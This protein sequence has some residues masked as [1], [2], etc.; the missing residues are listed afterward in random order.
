MAVILASTSAIRLQLLAAAGVSVTVCPARVDESAIR[1]ALLADRASPRD[2]VDYLAEV[3]ARKISE[4]QPEALVLGC[5]QVL[6]L[7]GQIL[8]KPTSPADARAQL[9]RLRG[10]SHRLLSAVVAYESAKPVWRYIGE[11]QLTMRDISDGF[12]DDYLARNWES[13]RNSVGGYKIE[14]EGVRLFSA[15]DGDHFT[16]LGLPLLP[17]LAWLGSRGIIAT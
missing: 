16:I 4:K 10:Q 15:I 17:L 11:A 3:K 13:I 1:S 9:V 12:L 7:D 2:V 14:E 6:V 5:D 8:G